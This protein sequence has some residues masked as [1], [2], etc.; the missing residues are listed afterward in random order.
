M[1]MAYIMLSVTDDAI[2]FF[3]EIVYRNKNKLLSEF[4][5]FLN[6]DLEMSNDEIKDIINDLKK[7]G[8][9]EIGGAIFY[10]KQVKIK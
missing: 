10:I 7:Y 2:D 8:K 3:D 4:R 1:K 6:E 9:T 5:K